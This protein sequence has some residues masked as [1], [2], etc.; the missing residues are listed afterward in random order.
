[1]EQE[2][3]HLSQ[4]LQSWLQA[5]GVPDGADS[6]RVVFDG[7]H[8][9]IVAMAGTQRMKLVL[10]FLLHIPPAPSPQPPPAATKKKAAPRRS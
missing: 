4:H 5:Q 3:A 7:T 8:A 2:T 9:H 10:P 6:V 1:M